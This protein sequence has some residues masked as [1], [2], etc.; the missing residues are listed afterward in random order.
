MSR[1][2][3]SALL[4]VQNLDVAYLPRMGVNTWALVD[5]SFE[6]MPGEILGI[7]GESGSGKSTLAA[8]LA[9][10]LPESGKIHRGQISLD[11]SQ[12]LR[13]SPSGLQKLRGAQISLIFQEPFM[14]LHPTMRV[15]DQVSEVLRAHERLNRAELR[16]NA[17]RV[18]A[19]VFSSD[20]ER[21]ARSYPHEL[22]GGQRQRVLIAQ[23]IACRPK[24]VVADEPTAC[25]DSTT[26]R[27]ILALFKDLRERLGVAIV[28]IT[29]NPALLP[30]FADRVLVLY[31]GR[32]VEWG[33]AQKVLF[34]PQHPYSKALLQCVPRFEETC[35]TSRKTEL[36]VIGGDSPYSASLADACAFVPRCVDRMDVCQ[37]RQPTSVLVNETHRVFCFKFSSEN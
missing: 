32:V 12:L 23:A 9:N 34:S 28:F 18:L 8:S 25:L 16:R 35:S 6:I 1:D 14:A 3:M 33:P 19:E 30:G 24:L 20:V 37:S 27:E 26:Q 10:L 4:E 13:L 29:H 21:I 17:R 15:G 31:A 2:T 7:L 36:K 11:G 5:I 22:S